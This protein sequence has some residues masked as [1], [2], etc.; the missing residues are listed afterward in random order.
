MK[1]IRLRN[2]KMVASQEY[3]EE[4]GFSW[5]H[6]VVIIW[7]RDHD[8]RILRLLDQMPPRVLDGLLVAHERKGSISFLWDGFVPT[9]YEEDG[10]L[11]EPMGDVWN[12]YFSRTIP[13][14]NLVF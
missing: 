13:C 9:E 12:I 14:E 2:L 7:D 4:Y 8:E 6:G 3:L 10:D 1:V 5:Y 11:N